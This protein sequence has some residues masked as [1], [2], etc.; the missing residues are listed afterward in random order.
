MTN[1]SIQIVN[2]IRPVNKE[3]LFKKIGGIQIHNKIE[4]NIIADTKEYVKN[5]S[6]SAFE[7]IMNKNNNYFYFYKE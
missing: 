1:E 3:D 4:Q 5:L 2:E 6:S 7:E